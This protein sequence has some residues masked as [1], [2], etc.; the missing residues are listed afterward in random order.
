M[1]SLKENEYSLV[2]HYSQVKKS[3]IFLAKKR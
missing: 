1:V 3:Q 2:N